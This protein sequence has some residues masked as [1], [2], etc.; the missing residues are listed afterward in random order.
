VTD[1]CVHATE[2]YVVLLKTRDK[3]RTAGYVLPLVKG[4]N[5]HIW[6]PASV[7]WG[8]L[9]SQNCRRL[10]QL[11]TIQQRYIIKQLS[12]TSVATAGAGN[13]RQLPPPN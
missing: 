3:C 1:D 12:C 11:S 9:H 5:E 8:C 7:S 6:R 13:G 4:A 2:H 10:H